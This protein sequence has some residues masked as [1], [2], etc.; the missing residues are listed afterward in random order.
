VPHR[1]AFG[2]GVVFVELASSANASTFAMFPI[3]VV[4][5]LCRRSVRCGEDAADLVGVDVELARGAQVEGVRDRGA[6]L[7]TAQRCGPA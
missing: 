4:M 2:S 1:L 5:R 6:S 3:A 7:A